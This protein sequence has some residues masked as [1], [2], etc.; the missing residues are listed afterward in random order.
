MKKWILY[1][2]IVF[3]LSSC[4]IKPPDWIIG[5]WYD[6][7]NS[8]SPEWIFTVDSIMNRQGTLKNEFFIDWTDMELENRYV[9]QASHVLE[10]VPHYEIFE[11]VSNDTLLY[12]ISS[13]LKNDDLEIKKVKLIKK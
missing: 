6:S 2:S 8:S 1:I 12:Y 3:T 9:L 5:K 7:E 11:K 13:N 10:S 4:S